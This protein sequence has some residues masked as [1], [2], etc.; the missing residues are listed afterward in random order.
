M[1]RIRNEYNQMKIEHWRS[2]ER[3]PPQRLQYR[4]LLGVCR[5]GEGQPPTGQHCDTSKG[6]R[7]L[8]WNP[9]EAAHNIE[10]HIWYDAD[11]TIRS[12]DETFDKQLCEVLN[13]NLK[14]LMNS[15]REA[16]EAIS[17]W[18]TIERRR[19]KGPVPP[20]RLMRKLASITAGDGSLRPFSR[21]A[22]WWV[23][24]KLQTMKP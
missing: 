16:L 2:H 21:V 8:Q 5:G 20:D 22:A 13:L 15:R 12:D 19:L 24:K 6:D 1:G 7:D 10:S 23:E 17:E 11:G 14:E 3:Y 4:N 9:A 18:W